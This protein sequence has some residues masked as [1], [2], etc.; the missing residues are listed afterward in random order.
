MAPCVLTLIAAPAACERLAAVAQATEAAL[1]QAGARV[2]APDW[3]APGAACDLGFD[4]LDPARATA[5]ARAAC[6]GAAI[7]AVAQPR[8]GRRKRLLVADLESTVIANEMLEEL[9]D[10][11]GR[12]D[13]V[14]AITRRAMNGEVDFEGALAARVALLRGLPQDVLGAAGRRIRINPGAAA[15]VA[16]MRAHG[17]RTALVSGGFGVF[18][19][20]IQDAL[21]FDVAVANE[22]VIESGCLAGTVRSPVLTA[23]GKRATLLRLAGEQGLAPAAT[24]A[25]GDGANDVPMIEAAGLG[26]AYHGKPAVA[27]RAPARIDHADLAALLYVQ[28]YRGDEFAAV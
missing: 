4:A 24:L 2:A 27:A 13:E 5:V 21:G 17:A 6:A 28:G 11:I 8:A 1:T 10:A 7:D 26:I 15:L 20:M 23:D 12:R 18:A 25:V 22:L 3:L 14:A 16:T 19:R 9:A